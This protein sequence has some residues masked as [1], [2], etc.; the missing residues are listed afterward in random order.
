MDKS[1]QSGGNHYSGSP[2]LAGFRGRCPRCGTGPL[3]DGYLT[4]A[5]KCTHC[6]LDNDYVDAADG[7][8]VVVIL[9]AGFI[10]VVMALLVEIYYMPPYWVHALL[11]LPL[12]IL[13][14]LGMLRPLK[15]W[16]V[17]MQYRNNAK[18]ARFDEDGTEV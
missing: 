9:L 1:K 13:I 2:A 12:G 7:P 14:P 8:A 6:D 4:L 11:W 16:F 3:F 15:G 17:A 5:E 10:V 18:Q